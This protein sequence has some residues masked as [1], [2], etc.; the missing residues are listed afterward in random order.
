MMRLQWKGIYPRK[1]TRK[2]L[3]KYETRSNIRWQTVI[4]QAVE[5]VVGLSPEPSQDLLLYVRGV[6]AMA[7]DALCAIYSRHVLKNI[8]KR[9]RLPR[10]VHFRKI[11]KVHFT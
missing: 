1:Q 5:T 10:V 4:Q 3:K 6:G 9:V 11:D 8:S 2:D 7:V